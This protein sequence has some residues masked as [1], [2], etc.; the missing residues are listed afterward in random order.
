LR[1]FEKHL[2]EFNARKIRVVAISVDPPSVSQHLRETQGYSFLI[3]AD[4][5]ASVIRAWDL[6]HAQPGELDIARPAE[7]LLDSSGH[8]RWLNLTENYFV[9]SRPGEVL[10]AADAVKLTQ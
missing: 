10:R 8:V 9:R 5:K 7:F 4:E 3:L 1:S 6:V 2:P